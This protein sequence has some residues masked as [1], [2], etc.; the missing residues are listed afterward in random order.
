M[1]CPPPPPPANDSLPARHARPIS[2]SLRAQEMN[3]VT[4]SESPSYPPLKFIS[5]IGGLVGLAAGIS[6]LTCLE[7]VEWVFNLVFV[8][9]REVPKRKKLA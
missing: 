9:R 6:A 7:I 4:V 5:E 3:L 2:T 1:H 8:W